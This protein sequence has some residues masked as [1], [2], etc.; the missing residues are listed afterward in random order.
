MAEPA[1]A[2]MSIEEFLRWESPEGRRYDLVDGA[3][4]AMN[5]PAAAH[6]IVAL[7]LGRRI[8]EALD[9]RRPCRVEG[10]AG[11]RIPGKGFDYYSADLA[12]T[13]E[14]HRRGQQDLQKPL[15]IVEVLSP[16]TEGYDRKTKLPDYRA[17]PSVQEIAFVDS[18]TAYAEVHRRLGDDRWLVEIA[19]G[20][21]AVLR[22][23]S[24]GLDLPLA[25]L[26]ED[27]ELAEIQLPYQAA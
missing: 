18:E 16:G 1:R 14:P 21:E 26:Y 4:F 24:V 3:P 12:V 27:V 5:P 20:R 25:A 7:R 19:R 10:E 17:I 23:E 6:R 15:L 22:L 11:L 8:D 13:C 9:R 2:R